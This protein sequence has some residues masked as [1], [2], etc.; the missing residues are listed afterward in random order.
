MNGLLG[1]CIN[2]TSKVRAY[3]FLNFFKN[4]LIWVFIFFLKKKQWVL[5]GLLRT[6]QRC[7]QT[8]L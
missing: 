6:E 4:Q 3:H 5:D 8:G 1:D 7:W 2:Q